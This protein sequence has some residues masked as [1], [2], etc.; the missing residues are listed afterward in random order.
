MARIVLQIIVIA[1]FP[2]SQNPIKISNGAS[3]SALYTIHFNSLLTKKGVS[4][5]H[6]FLF[7]SVS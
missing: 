3:C 7:A 5:L 6:L 2:P 4:C 1:F